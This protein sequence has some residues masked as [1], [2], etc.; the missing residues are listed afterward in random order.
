MLQQ[1]DQVGIDPQDESTR[2]EPV[3]DDVRCVGCGY[4]LRGLSRTGRCPECGAEI[5][6]SVS[7]NLLVL[8]AA[9]YLEQLHRGVALVLAAIVTQIVFV[10]V[11][12]LVLLALPAAQRGG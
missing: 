6:R 7:G 5:V 11:A 10:V 3:G 9:P 8:S 1:S 12:A 4:D 2:C